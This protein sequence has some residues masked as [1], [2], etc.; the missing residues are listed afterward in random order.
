MK[1]ILIPGGPRHEEDGFRY[2][3]IGLL[4]FLAALLWHAS[5]FS[6]PAQ[7]PSSSPWFER[8]IVGMEV[9]PTGAQWGP[10]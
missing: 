6:L 8:A 10:Q 9:G 2:L 7:E 3:T 4:S 1:K 5:G